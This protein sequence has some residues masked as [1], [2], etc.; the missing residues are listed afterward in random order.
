MNYNN[1]KKSRFGPKH[2]IAVQLLMCSS[3]TQ[4]VRNSL[5]ER[6]KNSEYASIDAEA[7]DFNILSVGYPDQLVGLNKEKSNDKKSDK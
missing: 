6:Q 5:H 7:D 4:A 1:G 3:T 2:L